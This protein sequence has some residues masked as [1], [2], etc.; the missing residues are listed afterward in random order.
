MCFIKLTVSIL[1]FLSSLFFSFGVTKG[2]VTIAYVGIFVPL[3]LQ[4]MWFGYWI[5]YEKNKQFWINVLFS[6]LFIVSSVFAI[7][8]FI[9]MANIL[10]NINNGGLFYIAE[11]GLNRIV[12]FFAMM[13]LWYQKSLI[14]KPFLYLF[15]SIQIIYTM[16]AIPVLMLLLYFFIVNVLLFGIKIFF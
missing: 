5:K 16:I 12:F 14:K 15:R 10:E 9:L 6:F 1:L 2:A 3:A 13:C 4:K 8:I 7:D 11:I